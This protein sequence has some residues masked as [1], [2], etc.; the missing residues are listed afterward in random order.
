MTTTNGALPPV[1]AVHPW[2]PNCGAHTA[3]ISANW[4]HCPGRDGYF[5]N[6]LPISLFA[7]RP[8]VTT[9]PL[10]TG[11]LP[12]PECGLHLVDS[13]TEAVDRVTDALERA[14]AVVRA[15]RV[16]TLG[17]DV[18]DAFYLVEP[19]PG[20]YARTDRR[21]PVERAVLTAAAPPAR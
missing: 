18:V 8:H 13:I 21:E 6:R 10:N 16:S 12:G 3:R 2:R 19:S 17:A 1:L 9:R 4:D 14:G 15:A 7:G 20:W 5:S 11:W